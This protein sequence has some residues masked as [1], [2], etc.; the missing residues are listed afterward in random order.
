LTLYTAGF[1]DVQ[2]ASNRMIPLAA[3][4]Q[5]GAMVIEPLVIAFPTQ[6]G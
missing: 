6:T 5:L 4:G 3:L 2:I 1:P